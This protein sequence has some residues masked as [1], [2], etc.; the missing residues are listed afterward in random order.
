MRLS[1]SGGRGKVLASPPTQDAPVPFYELAGALNTGQELDFSQLKGKRVLLVNTASNCGYTNQYEELQ[2]LS[3]Q[4][5]DDLV[6]LGFPANDF[7]EQEQADDHAIQQFC[8]VNFGVSFPLM[9]KSVVVKQATQNPVYQWLTQ[10]RQ[11]GWNEQAPDWN[12]SKYLVSADG[13]LTHYFGPAVSPL[14]ETIISHLQQ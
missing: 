8:Q 10:A 9:K 13:R 1:K 3:E 14:S 7:K 5:A 6:I 12:F 11:N 2:Q 4:F